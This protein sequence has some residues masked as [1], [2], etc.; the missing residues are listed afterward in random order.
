MIAI[1][2]QIC[3]DN[4]KDTFFWR[5]VTSREKNILSGNGQFSVRSLRSLSVIGFQLRGFRLT[6][7]TPKQ[8][9]LLY[10]TTERVHSTRTDN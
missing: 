3:Y 2:S 7:E 6:R 10:L 9:T 1:A 8:N 5:K 4:I